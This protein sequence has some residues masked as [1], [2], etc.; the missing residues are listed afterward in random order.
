M[1]PVSS[2]ITPLLIMTIF[3]GT[4]W[5]E[6]AL[7]LLLIDFNGATWV[8]CNIRTSSDDDGLYFHSGLTTFNPLSCTEIVVGDM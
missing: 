5:R 4:F 1:L 3:S 6:S 2:P 7:V 8:W